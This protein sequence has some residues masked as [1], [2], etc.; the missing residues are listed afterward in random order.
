[1]FPTKSATSIHNNIK[2]LNDLQIDCIRIKDTH[3]KLL[4]KFV[5][6]YKTKEK[7]SFI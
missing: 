7:N 1:M 6:L 4:L 2:I 3:N 5:D